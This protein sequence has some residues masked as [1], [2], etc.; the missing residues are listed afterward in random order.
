MSS[1]YLSKQIHQCFVMN[2]KYICLD[3]NSSIMAD[4]AQF[5]YIVY[6]I[7]INISYVVSYKTGLGNRSI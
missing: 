3:I 5:N 2:Q 6:Y 4:M 1:L 7:L